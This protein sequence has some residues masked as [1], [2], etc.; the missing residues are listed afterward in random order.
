MSPGIRLLHVVDIGALLPFPVSTTNHKKVGQL[1]DGDVTKCTAAFLKQ[2][3]VRWLVASI[4]LPT[5]RIT[6]YQVGVFTSPHVHCHDPALTVANNPSICSGQSE[7]PV[8]CERQPEY[9]AFR[10]NNPQIRRCVFQCRNHA[11]P[12]S[13]VQ[14]GIQLLWLPWLHKEGE[15]IEVCEIEAY[16]FWYKTQWW[17][18][19]ITS[20]GAYLWLT[21]RYCHY[22]HLYCNMVQG[23]H[24]RTRYFTIITK[25]FPPHGKQN[26]AKDSLKTMVLHTM[27]S[28][29]SCVDF[30]G[31]PSEINWEKL[32]TFYFMFEL[33][34]T[35]YSY[36]R[37]IH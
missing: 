31:P 7:P 4:L 33:F 12:S 18:I 15:S 32:G 14:V 1:A 30:L 11:P 20:R 6:V 10:A 5:S 9:D 37:P 26:S 27:Q 35:K 17:C 16:T 36:Y 29:L 34:L 2:Q 22:I 25:N 24:H 28:H 8:Q 19:A 13:I 21:I 23:G 3:A